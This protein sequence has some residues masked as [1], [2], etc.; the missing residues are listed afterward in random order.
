M[1]NGGFSQFFFNSSGDFS[2][3]T[4]DALKVIKAERTA[5]LL[6]KAIAEFPNAKVPKDTAERRELME[7]IGR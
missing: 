1:N 7:K 4:L 3:E 2:H 5:I 6:E